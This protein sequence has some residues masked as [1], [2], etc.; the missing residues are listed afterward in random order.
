MRHACPA[1][2]RIYRAVVVQIDALPALEPRLA[3]SPRVLVVVRSASGRAPDAA[4]LRQAFGLS[5]SEAL[6]AL[7]LYAGRS[8]E[9]IAAVRGA[10]VGTVRQQVKTVLHKAGVSREADLLMAIRRLG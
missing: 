6:I 4:V 3:L 5:P 7:E 2:R 10:A 8:R 1:S 9:E